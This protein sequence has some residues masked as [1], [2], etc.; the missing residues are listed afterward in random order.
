MTYS[1]AVAD[2]WC[3]LRLRAAVIRDLAPFG[4][5]WGHGDRRHRGGRG[6]Q[7]GLRSCS[8]DSGW[9]RDGKG[10]LEGGV[11]SREVSVVLE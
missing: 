11:W 10:C 9:Y 2:V 6:W 3:L 1:H 7:V 4:Q 8:G 5:Q